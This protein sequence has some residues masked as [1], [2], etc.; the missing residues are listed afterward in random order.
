[1]SSNY[2]KPSKYITF[3]SAWFKYEEDGTFL[4]TTAKVDFKN[5]ARSNKKKDEAQG[6][7]Y[8]MFL[9]PVDTTGEVT[10]SPIE[11]DNFVMSQV[12]KS[13]FPEQHRENAPDLRLWVG[14]VE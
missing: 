1:M 7:G 9:V 6:Q 12:D 11:V 4:R 13:K 3:G 10:G 14:I 8:K 5:N 2:K